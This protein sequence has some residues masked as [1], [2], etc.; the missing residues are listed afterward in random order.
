MGDLPLEPTPLVGRRADLAEAA[1]LL[2]TPLCRLLTLVGPG[3]VGK[4]RLAIHLAAQAGNAFPDGIRFVSLQGIAAPDLL[5]PALAGALRLPLSGTDDP[6]TRLL[7]HLRAKAMLLVLDSFEHLLDGATLLADLLGAAP[8]VKLVVSSRVALNLRQEWLY[9]V[10]GLPYPPDPARD[11]P[12]AEDAE[13][14]ADM[15][16]AQASPADQPEA[17]AETDGAYPAAQLFVERARHVRRDFSLEAEGAEVA[18]I[19]RLVGGLP[20]AIELAASWT[21]VLPC[22]TIADEITSGLG[23]L[24]TSLRDVPERHRSM[25]AVFDHSWRLLSDQERN[26]LARLSVFRGDFDRTAAE[27]V[28]GASLHILSALVDHSM[29]RA[30]SGGRYRLHDLLRQYAEARLGEMPG[31]A[32]RAHERRCAYYADFLDARLA[33]VLGG[34]Q[35]ESVAEIELEL[36]N[37]RTAWRWTI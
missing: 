18:R 24:A 37:V 8:R 27:Q 9:P 1:G 16:P 25:Q 12:A 22:A 21:K 14:R 4:T 26:V 33:D 7:G 20:L 3:G 23:M 31:A 32:D 34:R 11:R 13:A 6:R 30:E 2:A 36:D 28:T 17:H 5:V 19:C 35:R 29:L 15:A 10:Q